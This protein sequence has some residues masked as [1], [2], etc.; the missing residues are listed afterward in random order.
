MHLS[1]AAQD[2]APETAEGVQL[3]HLAKLLEAYERKRF[4]FGEP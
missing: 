4:K 2:P 3:E 1:I